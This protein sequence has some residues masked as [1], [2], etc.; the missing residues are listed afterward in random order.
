MSEIASE[1]DLASTFITPNWPA[2]ANVHAI[3]TT[4]AGGVSLAPYA[5]LNLGAHVKDDAMTVAHNRQ[6]LSPYLPSEPVWINQVHGIKAINA[7]MAGCATEADAAYTIKAHTVCVTM[8]ADCLPVLL[9]DQ[10]GTVIAAAHAGWKGLLDGVIESTIHSMLLATSGLKA[11]HLMAWL[12]PAIGP[13]AF[14]VGSEVC[15]AFMTVDANAALAFNPIANNKWLGDIYQLA[16]QRL[17]T[18][19]ISQIYGGDF[20]T[21]TDEARFFSYR[22]DQVTGRMATMIWL[23]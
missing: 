7:G 9:C 12:G 2:P 23:T 11:Q 20:C 18:I 14:E 6:L 16:R 19:G 21:Y 15:E 1:F 8:T 13:Q 10:A 5:S 17:N 22:R 3:Q 4:R